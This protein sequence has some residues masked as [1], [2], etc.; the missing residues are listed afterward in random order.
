MQATALTV[1]T[2]DPLLL[3]FIAG[4]L[5]FRN[6]EIAPTDHRFLKAIKLFDNSK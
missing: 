3:L 6:Y 4:F 2:E 5:C 1:A